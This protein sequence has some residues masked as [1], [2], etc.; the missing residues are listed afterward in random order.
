MVNNKLIIS[1][2]EFYLKKLT[3]N[4]VSKNY[5]NWF[6]DLDVKKYIKSSYNNRKELLISFTN[7][8][9]KKNQIF[10]GIFIKNIILG[11]K[12]Y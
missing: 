6:K 1:G 5:L 2:D 9:K 7:E 11:R 4:N 8:V 12:I 3:L 10:L